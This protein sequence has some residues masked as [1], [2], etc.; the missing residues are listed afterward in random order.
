MPNF[1]IHNNN[2]SSLYLTVDDHMVAK[3]VA[4]LAGDQEC[5][6]QERVTKACLTAARKRDP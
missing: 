1:P 2:Y 3:E 6:D 4:P 5:F